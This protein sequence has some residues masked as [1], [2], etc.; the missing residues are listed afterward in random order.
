MIARLFV[1][2][3]P[4]NTHPIDAFVKDE[5]EPQRTNYPE[6]AHFVSIGTEEARSLMEAIAF[7]YLRTAQFEDMR[8]LAPFLELQYNELAAASGTSPLDHVLTNMCRSSISRLTRAAL[9]IEEIVQR[10]SHQSLPP[11]TLTDVVQTIA[12]IVGRV[13]TAAKLLRELDNR[14]AG[15]GRREPTSPQ[16]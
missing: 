4:D 5:A 15:A 1:V 14:L 11:D 9:S 3:S 2:R 6:D 8:H 12:E 16:T 7:F 13:E 10:M